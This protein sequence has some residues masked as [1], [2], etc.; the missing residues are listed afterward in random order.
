MTFDRGD[1]EVGSGSSTR[2]RRLR[3]TPALRAL[4]REHALRPDQLMQPLF[5]AEA[6]ELA[7]AVDSMPGVR[8]LAL[9][10]VAPAAERLFDAGVRAVLLFGIPLGKDSDGRS[11]AAENGVVPAA[12][13]AIRRA[14]PE[15]AIATDLCLC[16]YTDHGHCA[17]IADGRVLNDEAMETLGL[18]ALA[19]AS[20]GADLVAP[21][22]MLDG[23]VGAVRRALDGD[24]FTET[25][26]LAYTVKYAS[27][28]YGPFRDAAHSAPSFGDRRTHQMDPANAAEALREAELDLAEGAD[29]LMVKPAGPCLDVVHR[30]ATRFEGVPIAAYQVSGEYAALC[31]AGE[32][33][34]LDVRAASMESLLA[35]RRA[36][37][38]MIITYFAERAARWLAEDQGVSR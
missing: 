17:P 32:R 36:G 11:A 10:E 20:A 18:A 14:V 22:G 23:V 24:G 5:V 34:W 27:A 31:A 33:G 19:H 2:L 35:I 29:I 25:G 3:A 15:L 8:R 30:L 6:P 16:A 28:F 13:R 38:G 7:G 37:A 26:I 4:R 1:I 9:A 21:S 12:V